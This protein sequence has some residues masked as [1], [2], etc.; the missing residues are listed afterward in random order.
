MCG[1]SGRIHPVTHVDLQAGRYRK[2]VLREGRVV[3]AIL[4]NDKE[5]V[6]PITQLI[7]QGVDVSAYA[8]RLLDD[9]FDLKKSLSPS[10]WPQG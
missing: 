9:D 7:E 1:R 3:G 8:D 2:F 5:R 6:R 10:N 4:L